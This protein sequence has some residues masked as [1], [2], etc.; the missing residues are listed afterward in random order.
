MIGT[1]LVARVDN[2]GDVLLAGPAIRAVAAG[3]REVVL[4][5]G[6]HG[7]AAGELLP[8][9]SRVLEWRTPWIDPEPPPVN[10]AHIA[11]LVED[12]RR[13]APEQALIL[14]SFHQSPLPLALLLRL[15]GVPRISAISTD[16]PGS[17]LDVRRVVDEDA[18]VPEAERMLGL[19]AQAGF[20]LPPGD[21]GRLAVRRP[22][23]EV[24]HLTGPPGYVV[25]HPGVSAP[26]R[27]WPAQSW[28][29]LAAELSA[30][31][32]RVV[33]T[34]GPGE[35]ELTARIAAAGDAPDLGGGTTMAELAAVL[36]GAG[37]VVAANTGPA[38]LAAAVGTPVVSLFAPVVPAA[39]WAPYGVRSAVL[40]DQNAPCRGTRA[41]VCPVPGH[42][43][44]SSV[45]SQRVVEEVRRVAAPKE[46]VV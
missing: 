29:R 27:A 14:T 42:P 36:D 28:I 34:G 4:L 24:G 8:G 7:R 38:H 43:C 33:V 41:R 40:G 46:A 3:A 10:E 30:A 15:A 13:L 19:A 26:A 20:G 32:E 1:V 11:R 45:P 21:D 39:R 35:R 6:P 16:Y 22:L 5:A 18:D 37:A 23:P 9:V 17:L 25:L 31:G 12:V 2:A 44:L